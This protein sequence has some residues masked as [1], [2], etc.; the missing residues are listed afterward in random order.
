MVFLPPDSAGAPDRS[1]AKQHGEFQ[2][3]V[4]YF[5][6]LLSSNSFSVRDCAQHR[7]PSQAGAVR[8][9]RFALRETAM[10]AVPIEAPGAVLEPRCPNRRK[11]SRQLLCALLRA[12][13]IR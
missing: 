12:I 5:Y 3:F 9:G 7:K 1:L 4:Y 10:T 13:C 6:R 11:R 2:Y 8:L